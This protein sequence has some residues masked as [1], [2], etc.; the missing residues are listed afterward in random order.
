MPP[1]AGAAEFPANATERHDA[2]GKNFYA[3]FSASRAIGEADHGD[4]HVSFRRRS[5]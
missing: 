2:A 4:Q 1:D 3:V 5:R